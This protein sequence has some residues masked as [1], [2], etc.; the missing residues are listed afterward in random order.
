M[1]DV[2][3]L[4]EAG[5]TPL[6]ETP[7]AI[8]PAEKVEADAKPTEAVEEAAP[9]EP[10]EQPRGPDG[11]FIAHPRT[12]KLV[13]QINSLTAEKRA[14]ERDVAR[15]KSEAAELAKQ[16]QQPVNIDPADF[17]AQ[18]AHRVRHEIK[19]DRLEQTAAQVRALEA[20]AQEASAQILNAQVEELRAHI[21][22]IDT[23]FLPGNQGGPTINQ[24]MAEA[25]T[26]SENGALVAY[27][28]K[29]NPR[30]AARIASL[31]PVSALMAIGQISAGISNPKNQMKR[32]SQAPVPVQTVSGGTSSTAL[33]LETASFKDYE[34]A[35]L[36]QM[37]SS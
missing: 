10:V 25:I 15:M 18:T 22:D 37:A 20:K 31:D 27:H 24:V 35:R 12:E 34:K 3:P 4:A 2:T 13:S 21:P 30:E 33:N 17:D 28:L 14:I 32:I 5:A 11:K 36:Q 16:L 19:S 9:A 29:K 7:V 1:T 8:E 6:A 23:I 26:R